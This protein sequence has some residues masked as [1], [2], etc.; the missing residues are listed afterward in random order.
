MFFAL[1]FIAALNPKLLAVDL[2]LNENRRP[3]AMFASLLAA[4]IGTAVAIG[5]IDVF[6]VHADAVT[7]QGKASAGVDL[8]LGLLLL[9][10]GGVIMTGLLAHVWARRPHS[11]QRAGKKEAASTEKERVDSRAMRALR[12]PRPGV[13]VIIGVVVGLPGVA[14]LTALHNLIAG[15]Y[16]TA[17]QVVAVFVFVIIEFLL[18]I[19]PW[20]FLELWPA[21]TARVLRRSQVWLAGHA[22]ALIGGSASC[23]ASS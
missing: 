19:V 4:G 2:L 14:Y 3:Q 15:K 16:S 17:T 8:G 12:E 1:A 7:K 5:L 20:V 13:A 6:A 10:V 21:G 9:L 22:T 23:W 18:I 11:R